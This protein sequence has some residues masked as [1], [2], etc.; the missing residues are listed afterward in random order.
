M[1]KDGKAWLVSADGTY[2]I[3]MPEGFYS[4]S[5]ATSIESPVVFRSSIDGSSVIYVTPRLDQPR[6][7]SREEI[8]QALLGSLTNEPQIRDD[9]NEFA[10]G[11][12]IVTQFKLLSSIHSG[13]PDFDGTILS[14]FTEI[15]GSVWAFS[16]TASTREEAEALMKQAA[17]SL[18]KH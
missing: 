3:D 2:T 7:P 5:V 16:F 14:V 13:E 1:D 10:G 15:G 6:V 8:E 12:A 18:Q 4:D 17:D 11:P 9:L